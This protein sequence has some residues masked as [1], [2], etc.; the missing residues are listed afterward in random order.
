MASSQS[1]TDFLVI[2]AG[3]AG[4]RA[5]V[6]LASAGSVMV[7]LVVYAGLESRPILE[8][9]GFQLLTYACSY[10][11]TPPGQAQALEGALDEGE[12]RL[13]L[14]RALLGEWLGGS[15]GGW[16]DSGGVWPGMKLIQGVLASPSDPEHGISRGRLLPQH[17]ILDATDASPQTRRRLQDSLV[18][19]HGGMAQN[20]GP[21]LEMVTEKYLLRCD[22]E[23][24]A[25]HSML[26][27][28]NE[29]L[30]GLRAGD[31]LGN[32]PGGTV[33]RRWWNQQRNCL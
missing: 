19:V 22:A 11:W 31:R 26:G 17:R 28:L 5:A 32:L 6:E 4:L 27:I 8:S 23:W 12:R 30:G 7:L 20:V 9:H 14:A 33:E 3:V 1:H 16:Q 18:L 10:E 25:R 24:N 21:I 2:G 13:V 15:G 29:I